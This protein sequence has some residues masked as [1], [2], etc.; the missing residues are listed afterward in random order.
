[1]YGREAVSTLVYLSPLLRII[2][3]YCLAPLAGA[4][5][6][7]RLPRPPAQ[8]GVKSLVS[9]HAARFHFAVRCYPQPRQHSAPM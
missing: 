4:H 3:S 6:D 2:R 8:L 1:M 7:P 9:Q 5:T